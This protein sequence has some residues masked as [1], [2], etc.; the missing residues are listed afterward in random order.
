MN[1]QLLVTLAVLVGQFIAASLRA[2]EAHLLQCGHCA[3]MA[4]LHARQLA[5]EDKGKAPQNSYAP[6]RFVDVLHLKLDVTPDFKERSLT[7][8]AILDF[9]PIA[10]PLRQ[11]RL[12]AVG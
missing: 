6:D 2:N 9:Q 1:R 5:A 12:N 4:R 8:T 10:K 3:M 7:A 11:W